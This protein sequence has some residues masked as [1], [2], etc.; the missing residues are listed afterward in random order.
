MPKSKSIGI[1][2][3][4]NTDATFTTLYFCNFHCGYRFC[5]IKAH[6]SLHL[7]HCTIVAFVS[8]VPFVSTGDA[9]RGQA[10]VCCNIF[11][12]VSTGCFIS[13][14]DHQSPKIMDNGIGLR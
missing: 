7:A 14:A 3:R 4:I 2:P 1:D 5:H 6:L 10:K 8:T 13:T 9:F 11:S 12:K